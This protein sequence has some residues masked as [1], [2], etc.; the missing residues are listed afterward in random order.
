MIGE[1]TISAKMRGAHLGM[2]ASDA[3]EKAATDTSGSSGGGLSAFI[4]RVL[5]QL[6]MSAWLPAGLLAASVT[7]LVWFRSHGRVD[8]AAAVSGIAA[9]RWGFLVLVIPL[10]LVATMITQA[11]SFIAIRAL[12]GY[13][14]GSGLVALCREL[15][16]RRH[17]RRQTNLSRR[18][19]QETERAFGIAR[20]RMLE[21][22]WSRFVVVR[23]EQDAL[24]IEAGLGSEPDVQ[25]EKLSSKDQKILKFASWRTFCDPWRLAK[26]DLLIKE[27]QRYPE[28][29]RMMPTKLGNI[30]RSTEDTLDTADGDLEGL[31]VRRKHLLPGRLQR[32]HD[33]YRTRLDMYAMFVFIGGF[34]A[35]LTPLML[36]GKV[37]DWW[38]IAITSGIFVVLGLAGYQAAIAS[39]E[40][41][42]G[43]LREIDRR[44]RQSY[45]C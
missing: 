3:E 34:L 1:S 30:L 45:G 41:Y 2:D 32:D 44:T 23:F 6:S 14:R 42:C 16:I 39:A 31:V 10:L 40:A 8:L 20:P 37:S 4:V 11:F 35:V 27:E 24:G 19:R 21:A 38:A 22:G 9:D 7:L 15:L 43:I 13:W 18:R 28:P 5:E 17:L 29:R 33:H 12:E 26:I 36:I 25:G